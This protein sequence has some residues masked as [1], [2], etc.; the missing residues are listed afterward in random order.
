VW[1]GGGFYSYRF[2]WAVQ[3]FCRALPKLRGTVDIF[4]RR[5]MSLSICAQPASKRL[6]K[7]CA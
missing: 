1:R 2:E 3:N 4:N 6:I 7:L 5:L